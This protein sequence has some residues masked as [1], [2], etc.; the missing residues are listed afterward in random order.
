MPGF[1]AS[2]HFLSCAKNVGSWCT[3]NELFEFIAYAKF[4]PDFVG[5]GKFL[6]VGF[7]KI[8][9]R[10]KYFLGGLAGNR[11][12]LIFFLDCWSSCPPFELR[13]SSNVG[14]ALFFRTFYRGKRRITFLEKIVDQR[15]VFPLCRNGWVVGCSCD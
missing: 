13:F 3:V 5:V 12:Y 2:Y 6:H 11:R 10:V 15:E 8:R 1:W 14:C 4:V 9:Q 7:E